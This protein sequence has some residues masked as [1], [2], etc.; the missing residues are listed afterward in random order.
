MIG[1]GNGG[2]NLNNGDYENDDDD[3]E[4]EIDES[5]VARGRI[6]AFGDAFRCD[7]CQWEWHCP[8]HFVCSLDIVQPMR[9]E[10]LLTLAK[11]NL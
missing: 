6:T 7:S 8:I 10:R 5:K 11:F 9:A 3:E 1:V 4:D 2:A